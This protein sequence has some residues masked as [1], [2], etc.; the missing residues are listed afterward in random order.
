[1]QAGFVTRIDHDA[2]ASVAAFDAEKRLFAHY[3]LEYRVHTVELREPNLRVRVLDVGNG[4]PVLIV[5]G[6]TR[7]PGPM[8]RSWAS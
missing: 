3:R 6:G 7:T 5:P 8:R 4:E 2:A 1:M